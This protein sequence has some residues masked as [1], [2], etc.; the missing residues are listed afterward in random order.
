V[1]VEKDRDSLLGAVLR[2]QQGNTIVD[3]M[4]GRGVLVEWNSKQSSETVRSGDVLASVNGNRGNF[5]EVA[6]ELQRVGKLHLVFLRYPGAVPPRVRSGDER[7]DQASLLFRSLGPEDFELLG[8]LDEGV[9]KRDLAPA[10]LVDDLPHMLARDCCPDGGALCHVCLE[11]LT[12]SD[13]LV[14]LPCK[15]FFHTQ[16]VSRWLTQC[17]NSCPL[18]AEPVPFNAESYEMDEV[19]ALFEVHSVRASS[20]EAATRG[21]GAS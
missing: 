16:C 7:F 19:Q 6:V 13:E 15:H 14:M 12:A 8:R 18:C 4:M 17:K 1:D 20:W 11:E 5:W 3:R 10:L 2:N 21:R 9:I